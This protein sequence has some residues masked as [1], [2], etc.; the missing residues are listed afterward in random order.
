MGNFGLSPGSTATYYL[1]LFF[2]TSSPAS[3]V[4][5][6]GGTITVGGVGGT[7]FILSDYYNLNRKHNRSRAGALHL[8]GRAS[9]GLQAFCQRF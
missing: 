5:F 2:S 6:T 1:S 7:G 4:G 3:L 9:G 8:G